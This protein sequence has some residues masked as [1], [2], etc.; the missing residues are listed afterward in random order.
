[1][2]QIRSVLVAL[3]SA[4]VIAGVAGCGTSSTPHPTTSNARSV[5]S[6]TITSAPAPNAQPG[7][8]D[9]DQQAVTDLMTQERDGFLDWMR[10]FGPQQRP[11]QPYKLVVTTKTYRSGTPTAGTQSLV[12]KISQDTGAAHEGHPDTTFN[13]LNYDLTKRAPITFDTL[14]KPGTNPL[15][16]LNPTVLR[17]LVH[18]SDYRVNDLDVHNYENFALTEDAVI[19]F[20]GQDEVVRDNNGPHQVSVPRTELAPLLA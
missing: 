4:A 2:N 15:E 8:V 6:T 12:F 3:A 18:G 16:V 1:M 14:F 20:F 19:F 7:C 13:A 9:P 11:D 5:Q 17:E 10:D